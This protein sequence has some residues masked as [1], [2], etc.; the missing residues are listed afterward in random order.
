M[1]LIEYDHIKHRQERLVG[2]AAQGQVCAQQ[3]VIDDHQV[4]RPGRIACLGH[5]AV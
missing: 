3:M 1:G 4:S 2:V 5:I